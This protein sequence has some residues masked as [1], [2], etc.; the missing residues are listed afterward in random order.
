MLSRQLSQFSVDF[1]YIFWSCCKTERNLAR[2]PKIVALFHKR[3]IEEHSYALDYIQIHSI[4]VSNFCLFFRW[5]YDE[6]G[7][8]Q[9]TKPAPAWEENWIPV[10]L[11]KKISNKSHRALSIER[12]ISAL[13]ASLNDNFY[14]VCEQNE[15][16]TCKTSFHCHCRLYLGVSWW[17]S[18]LFCS[19]VS[20]RNDL[21]IIRQKDLPMS[22]FLWSYISERVHWIRWYK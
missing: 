21:T 13:V 2:S 10:L 19:K 17:F 8:W 9:L 7:T 11:T 6:N 22:T 16:W 15:I 20:I 18:V 1:C 12:H 4:T 5:L 3:S 14:Y